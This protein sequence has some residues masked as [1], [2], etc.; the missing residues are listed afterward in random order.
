MLCMFAHIKPNSLWRHYK[1]GVYIVKELVVLESNGELFV[2]Y[3]RKHNPVQHNWIR[4]AREWEQ[5]VQE[6][7]SRFTHITSE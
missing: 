3:N 2:A 7:K 1:G 4:P 5:K 6:T